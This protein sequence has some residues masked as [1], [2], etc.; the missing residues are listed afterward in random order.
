MKSA[1]ILL[2]FALFSY[3]TIPENKIPKKSITFDLLH[4]RAEQDSLS[5]L[6]RPSQIEHD[7][8][9]S[10]LIIL[11]AGNH[12]IVRFTQKGEFIRQIGEIG[13]GPGELLRPVGFDIDSKGD[14]YILEEGNRRV[15]IFDKKGEFRK[16]FK[17]YDGSEPFS[18]CV[19]NPDEI[20]INQPQIDGAL[21]YCFD[22]NGEKIDSVG[23]VVSIKPDKYKIVSPINTWHFNRAIGKFNSNGEFLIFYIN[24]PQ[25]LEFDKTGK[26]KKKI[27]IKGTEIDYLEKYEK[28]LRK[29]NK[30]AYNKAVGTRYILDWDFISTELYLVRLG[31]IINNE[32][33]FYLMNKDGIVLEKYT[34]CPSQN[35]SFDYPSIHTF[36][37]IESDLIIGLDE[38][39]CALLCAHF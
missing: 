20:L 39:N 16:S 29:Q 18:I 35:I 14:I 24:I 9:D 22:Q 28:D 13:Q 32:K 2:F 33:Y 19:K 6:Y 37:A 31:G 17:L 36:C 11:D 5:L 38:F 15:S 8:S 26:L 21:F 27:I 7:P 4:N 1:S 3:C 10:S 30:P 12:R 25:F 34:I 23:R